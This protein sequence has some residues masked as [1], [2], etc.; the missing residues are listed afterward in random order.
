MECGSRLRHHGRI[1]MKAR[2]AAE[3][4]RACNITDERGMHL[5]VKPDGAKYWR[6]KY[7]FAGKEKLFAIGALRRK[8]LRRSHWVTEAAA[9]PRVAGFQSIHSRPTL[10]SIDSEIGFAAPCARPA[11]IG[12]VDHQRWARQ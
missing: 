6:L 2:T 4:D 10:A 11:V 8:G 12:D 7:Q 3:R 5:L 9:I 1:K